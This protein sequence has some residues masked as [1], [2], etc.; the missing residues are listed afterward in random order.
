MKQFYGTF[1]RYL[2]VL[3]L[4]TAFFGAA[5]QGVS[6]RGKVTST[7]DKSGIPGVNVVE[8]GTSNGTVTD[9]DGNYSLNVAANAVVVFTFVGYVTQEVV[10]GGRTTLDVALE[11]DVKALEE[12]VVIGYGSVEAKDVTGTLVSLKS[13][14]FNQGLVSSPEQLMQ[15]RVAGV[16][17]TSN[18]GEPG[19]INTIR[20][21]GTSSV[22]GGNQPLYVV[23]GVPITNDDIGNGSAG[24]AGNTP[25]RNPLNFLNSNDIASMDILKDASA[26]AIYGSR[27]ANGV[28]IITT[29]KGRAGTPKLDF[30]VQTSLSTI[31]KKYDLLDRTAFLAAYEKYNGAGSAA[32]LDKG[33]NTDW[34]DA[35]TRQAFSKQYNLSYGGGDKSSNYMFSAGYLDQEGIVKK[36]GLKRFSLRF[37]GDK[38]FLNDKLTVS[39]SFTVAETHDD[40]VPITVNSGFEGDLW[41]NALKQAPSNPIYSSTD[42][43]G[44]FQL[45]NTEPNPVA[46]LNLSKI[47]TNS[48]RSLGSISAEYEIIKGLKFKTLYGFDYTITEQRAAY[49]KL[50]N[51]TGIYNNG[52]AYIRDNRQV[53]N[54]W[55][56]YF[57]YEKKFGAVNFTGL[58]GYSYQNFNTQ[59]IGFEAS[60]FRTNSVDD[61]LNNIASSDQSKLGGVVATN[62]S[63][64][65]DELQS[66]FGRFTA[67]L[68]EKYII[69]ATVRADGSTR[70]GPDYKYGIFPS[71]AFKW[72][73]SEEAFI[74]DAFNDLNMRISYGIT[75]NQQFGHNL[76]QERWRYGGAI[77]TDWT[78][79]TAADNTDR[80]GYGPVSFKNDKLKW[81]STAQFNIGF[82]FGFFNNRL[83]G[84]LDYYNKN[85]S[86]LLTLSYSAQPAPNRFRY[87]NL[88]ANIINKGFELGLSLD[89]IDGDDFK[90]NVAYNMAYN[91]NEVKNLNTFYNAGEINGQGLSG[92][93]SQRIASGQPLYAFYVREFVQYDNEGIALYRDID[94]QLKRSA[95]QKFVGKSPLP[96]WN[97][98]LTNTLTYKNFDLTIFFS[99]QLGQYVYSN[100]ANAFFSAGSL[101]NGR[102][103]TKDI[104]TTTENKLN[105]PDV[106]DRFLYNASF[107][108]LQ[109]VTLG[110][111]LKTKGVFQNLRIYINGSNLAV[112]TN[113]PFQDP[114]VSVPKPVTLGN[115]PPVAVAGIDYT[116]YPRARTFAL[117]INATF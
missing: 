49:S 38:K 85:T 62:S 55:E 54:L 109:N 79:N 8:K 42:P 101:A 29:K 81:E 22:I 36:S 66:Y 51:V 31:T 3:L 23:D 41:G 88:P 94:G 113:Y 20:V 48:L 46:M 93:Y 33:G 68:G 34:Q 59:A 105:A 102:N 75:G 57:T 64:T 95:E 12:V 67:G 98:G 1:C 71:G 17:I 47:Y 7:D 97:L 10:V 39:T 69:T 16:Q 73:L 45:A 24:G 114:E 15:G 117:G 21:R 115:T 103:T 44:Y 58:L 14:S 90:W 50:L 52:R 5:G 53:N 56:N 61:M 43:S 82:D 11:A 37:N 80:G 9:G 70:F 76:Y 6:I 18:S 32:V 87:I 86:D 96:K 25:A 89:A 72:R 63:N 30:S 106:S 77:N 104:P 107:V 27:G 99:G 78:I 74:P 19:A 13:E 108:R 35:V 83:R 84:T 116:T 2:T 92:A 111:N 40:Q 110:Y 28:I 91:S 112:F 65:T 100:T 60:R 26:T 4:L